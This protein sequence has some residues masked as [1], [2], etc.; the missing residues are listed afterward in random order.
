MMAGKNRNR[1]RRKKVA[2]TKCQQINKLKLSHQ[3]KLL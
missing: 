2:M 1:F 3:I